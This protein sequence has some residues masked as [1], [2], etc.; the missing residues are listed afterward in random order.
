MAFINNPITY[1]LLRFCLFLELTGLLHG[2]WVLAFIHKKLAGWQRD[3]YYIG[4]AE[5][6]NGGNSP[7][8]KENVIGGP[9]HPIPE[10]E[11]GKNPV[12][13][14]SVHSKSQPATSEKGCDDSDEAEETCA[15][16]YEIESA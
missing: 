13:S 12:D 9:G 4:T 14:L 2:A 3:E 8:R 16:V 6:R 1:A 10:W 11:L 15:E 5:E 7:D